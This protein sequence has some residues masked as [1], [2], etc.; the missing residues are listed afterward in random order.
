MTQSRFKRIVTP[1]VLIASLGY[2]VDMFDITL[3]G[4]VMLGSVKAMG[5]TTLSGMISTGV[6]LY[7]FQMGGML[8]G[9]IFWGI[10]GD[11]KGRH[12]VLY[13]SILMYSVANILNAFVT[14]T[15]Q[16]EVLRFL[17]GVGLA[18]EL[19]A[20]VTM[21]AESLN[22]EDRGYATTL[23]ATLGMIGSLCAAL[24]GKYFA[25]NHA[26]L[27]GGIL[28][29]VLLAA[30]LKSF[31][32]AMFKALQ[33]KKIVRGNVKL[34]F[35]PKRALRYLSSVAV[36]VP[37][38]FITAIL[39]TL[40]P[41]VTSELHLTAPVTAADALIWGSIGLAVGDMASGL[42][43]QWLKSRKKAIALFLSIA[44]GTMILYTKSDGATPGFIHLLCFVLGTCAG[45][46]A[47][48][49][50]TAAEQFGTDIRS[51]VATTVPNFVRGSG[52]IIASSFLYLKPHFTI[53]QTVQII[54][55]VV[56]AMG[57]LS[58]LVLKETYGKDLD[59]VEVEEKES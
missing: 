12:V 47:V 3:F 1:T 33:H 55:A 45:Y 32:S 20:A 15:G 36:G 59:F 11:K 37:I 27:I 4:V 16:Y 9:G 54:G 24:I 52:M 7:N 42:L 23:V 31:D 34:L 44:L 21:V 58:L 22:K 51:T 35:A 53:I 40:A 8:L 2:F 43:S 10:L 38:Y 17:A 19:G 57:F 30:R 5:E 48:L 25:W 29:L 49:V 6:K 18:G 26:Y 13:S 28:G 39:L 14:T 50:T 46:W 56:F 41:L